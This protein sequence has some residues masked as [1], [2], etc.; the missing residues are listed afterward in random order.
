MSEKPVKER[1]HWIDIAKGICLI[2]VILGHLDLRTW[3]FVYSFH[4][5]VFFILSGYTM[6]KE[7][8]TGE[9]LKNKFRRLMT[10]YFFTCTAVAGM[11]IVNSVVIHGDMT[12]ATITG[13]LS[14]NLV[15]GFFGSGLNQQLGEIQMGQ[16]VGAIWFLPALF[17]ALIF[18]QFLLNTFKSRAGQMLAGVGMAAVGCISASFIWLPFSIQ[19]AMLAVPFILFGMWLKE[20]QLLEKL[21]WYHYVVFAAV[22]VAGCMTEYAQ[23]FW[24]VSCTVE[25]WFFTPLCA[26]CSS[27]VLLGISKM[28]KRLP[29]LEFVGRNSLIFLCVHVFEMYTLYWVYPLAW[30]KLHIPEN[31]LSYFIIEILMISVISWV[32]VKFQSRKRREKAEAAQEG[33]RDFSIDILRALLIVL[34]IVGHASIDVRLFNLIYSMHM[35]AFIMVSGYFFKSGMPFGTNLK[36]SLKM[37]YPYVLFAIGYFF[38][39]GD[40]LAVEV[41]NLALGMS[42]A[43]TLFPW[44]ASVGP[45]YFV[46]LLF[47]TRVIYI[48]VDKCKNEGL[49]H[50]IVI[51]LFVLGIFLGRIGIWLPW[52]LDCAL[53][54]V[55]FYHI[56]HYMRKYKVLEACARMPQVYFLVSAVWIFMIYDGG[57]ELARRY[58]GDEGIMIL[59]VCAAFIL[60]YLLCRYFAEHFPKWLCKGIS[61]IGQSTGYILVLH[62]LFRED[63]AVFLE[64]RLHLFP[65]NIVFLGVCIAVQVAAGVL[66]LLVVNGGKRLVRS[67]RKLH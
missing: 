37:L 60:L 47:G 45:V 52:S 13:I 41:R 28:I 38:V 20:S 22:F 63:L 40:G 58:Y 42:F 54:C 24:V 27:L 59:G 5:T 33:P 46:L 62:T 32:I 61:L 44:A 10:P 56:A 36:K 2:A 4:L 26:I 8:L 39:T 1:I 16:N 3:G 18:V 23:L 50:A 12:T 21:K 15:R 55:L 7:A 6:R 29:P 67:F 43:H 49:K 34:M 53:V 19:S 11:E 64:E 57:M 66:V 14:D 9:Y 48:C 51:A 17:F 65:G 35:L 30:E 25:N 31:D